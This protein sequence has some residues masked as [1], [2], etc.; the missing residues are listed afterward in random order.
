MKGLKIDIKE[1]SSNHQ[2]QQFKIPSLNIGE[3]VYNR[4]S[5]KN[6]TKGKKHLYKNQFKK[7]CYPLSTKNAFIA[8]KRNGLVQKEASIKQIFNSKGKKARNRDQVKH[9]K[10][11]DKGVV[12][13]KTTKNKPFTFFFPDDKDI[14][15]NTDLNDQQT[16][17]KNIRVSNN[18]KSDLNGQISQCEHKESK[19]EFHKQSSEVLPRQSKNRGKGGN[20]KQKTKPY[21]ELIK[22]KLFLEKHVVCPQTAPH[23]ASKAKK[24]FHSENNK[25]DRQVLENKSSKGYKNY[26]QLISNEKA[27]RNQPF[28]RK[29]SKSKERKQNPLKHLKKKEKKTLKVNLEE[30]LEMNSKLRKKAITSTHLS[31]KHKMGFNFNINTSIEEIPQRT[32]NQ[33]EIT[34]SILSVEEVGDWKQFCIKLSKIEKFLYGFLEIFEKNNDPYDLIREY[35]DYIQDRSFNE[36]NNIIT[37]KRFNKIIRENVILERWAI[38]LIFYIFLE[39]K[40]KVSKNIILRISVS[41]YQNFIFFL[42]LI[43]MEMESI[44]NIQV[45]KTFRRFINTGILPKNYDFY[46]F[47]IS[48]KELLNNLRKSNYEVLDFLVDSKHLTSQKIANGITNL[49]VNIETLTI[50]ESLDLLL[51]SFCD[52]FLQKG[53]VTVEYLDQDDQ[54]LMENNSF[55][56]PFINVPIPKERDYTLVLD[57]DETLIHYSQSPQ[58]GQ[59]LLRPFVHKFLK[60]MGKYFEIIIFTAAQQDYADWI[61]NRLD[62]GKDVSHRLYRQHTYL[63]KN[64]NIKNL[65]R[66]GRNIKKTIIIDNIAD[67]FQ[68]QPYNGIDIKTWI[69][70]PDDTVLEDLIPLLKS[71]LKSDSKKKVR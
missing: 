64:V 2:K 69:G 24:L 65:D 35:V 53:I 6:A 59:V 26:G 29:L 3:M 19:T 43:S 68:L 56:L 12:K 50:D 16:L 36:F 7:K 63:H 71:K 23:F 51:D 17:Y 47:K 58:G 13:P 33:T 48:K 1:I 10:I 15:C 18:N 67:N 57:L 38:F 14:E 34:E 49:E 40:T 5:T 30:E 62:K 61:L 20:K 55:G 66:L 28:N 8:E 46:D 27:K 9:S 44:P 31:Q 52:Y 4:F 39:K 22:P 45:S 41:I 70:D 11:T 42:K 25:E 37:E 32:R 54:L 21:I 60:E